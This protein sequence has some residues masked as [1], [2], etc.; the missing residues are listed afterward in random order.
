MMNESDRFI[1]QQMMHTAGRLT[2]R[3]TALIPIISLVVLLPACAQQAENIAAGKPCTFAPDPNYGLTAR[4][5]TDG[6]DLTDGRLTERPDQHMWFESHAVGW[7]HVPVVNVRLDLGEV[8]PIGEVVI[9]VLG[10]SVQPGITHPTFVRVLVS[11]DDRVYH[12]VAEFS[13]WQQG[14]DE[15]FGIPPTEGKAWVHPLR[16]SDLK[17]RGRYVGLV[18][19]G[20]GLTCSDE[21]YVYRGAHDAAGVRFDA[22][23]AMDFSV[24]R[25]QLAF[26]KPFL[27]LPTGI[28]SPQPVGLLD[29][30]GT[31]R[32]VTLH[33]EAPPQV[34]I[35]IPECPQEKL[36]GGG[37]R[38]SIP[39]EA[40]GSTVMPRARLYMRSSLPAGATAALRTWLDWGDGQSAPST[41]EVR[42]ADMPPAPMCER[43]TMALGWWSLS[44]TR[45][46]PD[47][48][49]AHRAIGLNTLSTFSVWMEP[50]DIELWAFADQVRQQGFRMLDVDSTW[51][52]MI[53]RHK[54]DRS[55]YC[56]FADGTTNSRLCPSYRGPWYD[57]E[58]QRIAGECARLK[59]DNL[60]TDVE[61]W[62]WQGPVDAEKCT[63]CQAD[64]QTSGIAAWEDWKL[65]KG[66]EMWKDLHD[67]VQAAV[68][69]AGGKPVEMGCYDWRPGS[70][71]QFFW[72]FDRLYQD[73]LLH[74]SQTSVYTPLFAYHIEFIGKEARDDRAKLPKTDGLPWLTPGDAGAFTAEALRCAMLECFLNG[75]RGVHFWSNRYW[76]GEYLLGYNQAVREV[77]AVEDII[78]DGALFTKAQVPPG[79]RV[80]GMIRGNDIALL[81][82]Q[83]QSDSPMT[84]TVTLDVPAACDVVETLSGQKVGELTAGEQ[85]LPVKLEGHRSKVL[86]LRAR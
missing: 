16:F 75:S 15:R 13:R 5:G 18:I 39:L 85:Q 12:R 14:D 58:L 24:S 7:S 6:S 50:D 45:V 71:Y 66:Y 29:A 80:S 86:L 84:V 68:R 63:R 46:W 62:N 41:M 21:L 38:Y 65:Q 76:D 78:V 32:Q 26:V 77:A 55:L 17:T 79:A 61:L 28:A 25:P 81:V 31:K 23:S 56:Q 83:Y 4:G 59:P 48:L 70:N 19:G 52:R 36:D 35:L 49:Q 72:P 10:G 1:G 3:W 30:S 73:K 37:T 40:P 34:E 47:G 11:D 64:K 27:V 43:M 33:V 44:D 9:R 53:S 22:A 51:H 2:L 20:T 67:A 54:D 74:N 57:E 82:G 42:I 60:S 69:Q 8:Q